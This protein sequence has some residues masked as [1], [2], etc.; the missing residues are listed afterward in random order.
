[1]ILAVDAVPERGPVA[2][3]TDERFAERWERGEAP[4]AGI[5]H[6]EHL[7]IAWVLLRRHGRE[8]GGRRVLDGTRRAC[9]AAGVP[10]RFDARL[11][12]RW[13]DALADALE[14]PPVPG[15]LSE[16]LAR[17]PELRDGRRFG[18]PGAAGPGREETARR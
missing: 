1:M 10:E 18:R 2:S 14:E 8:A 4:S 16:L 17:H 11:T 9:E 3:L 5:S 12:R 13:T 6:E 7:R 15:S